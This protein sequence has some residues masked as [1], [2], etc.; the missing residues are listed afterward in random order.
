M[1]SGAKGGFCSPDL[2]WGGLDDFGDVLKDAVALDIRALMESFLLNQVNASGIDLSSFSVSG[3]HL[4]LW[5]FSP[6]SEALV[7]FT[8]VLLCFPDILH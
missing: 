8:V 6:G 4:Y 2:L 7:G 5:L 1:A 3:I